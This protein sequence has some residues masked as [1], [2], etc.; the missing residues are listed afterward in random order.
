MVD[1]HINEMYKY[2][3]QNLTHIRQTDD[4]LTFGVKVYLHEYWKKC[5]HKNCYKMFTFVLVIN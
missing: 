1:I 4:L 3:R 2:F 5:F